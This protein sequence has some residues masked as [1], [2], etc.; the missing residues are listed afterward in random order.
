MGELKL[1]RL[2]KILREF[3]ISLDRAVEFLAS[4]GHDIDARPTT[5]IS[6]DQYTL[7]L[8]EFSSD[9][10]SKVESHDLSEEKRKEKEELRIKLEKELEEKEKKRNS[11]I[12]RA[13]IKK[14]VHLGKI[15]L[16]KFN[17]PKPKAKAIP[18]TDSVAEPKL[19]AKPDSKVEKNVIIPALTDEI[20]KSEP[21]VEEVKDDSII[22]T[23]YTKLSGLKTVG[24]KIDLG[25]FDKPNATASKHSSVSKRKRIR[26]SKDP[27]K[28]SV[29]SNKRTFNKPG[30]RSKPVASEPSEVD[31]QKQIRETLEKLQ[32]RSSSKGA[33]YRKG[34][35]DSHKLKSD[36]ELAQNEAEKKTIKVTEFITVGEVATMMEIT[37]TEII[38]TCMSLGIMV[39][40]NQRLD[41]ETLTIVADEFGYEVEFV[42]ADIED[43]IK[44]VEDSPEDLL[45][46]APIVTVMGH[47]DHG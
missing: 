34:K 43:S 25:K 6:P 4:N 31:V 46:R 39:T 36:E 30:G 8:N 14:P 44:E 45:P 32:G 27:V 19:E 16:D 41:A 5:K 37:S 21:Q 20:I 3:N 10:S 42:T 1:K 24:D 29:S 23:K 38:S 13:E 26:I 7:F 22:K 28:P 47:V 35:R 12:E 15:D 33:K 40:M 2:N 9:K 18:A 11:F 17:K